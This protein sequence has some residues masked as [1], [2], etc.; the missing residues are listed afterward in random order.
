[1]FDLRCSPTPTL[2]CPIF[3]PF[4]KSP[5]HIASFVH[6]PHTHNELDVSSVSPY[7]TPSAY[8]SCSVQSLGRVQLFATP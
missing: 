2:L 8:S 5:F 6:Q 4:F 7:G 3:N 1:M